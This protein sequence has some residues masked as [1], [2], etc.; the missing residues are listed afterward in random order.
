MK[1]TRLSLLAISTLT[2]ILLVGGMMPASAM[3]AN[4]NGTPVET[5]RAM[6]DI[7]I[8]AATKSI[9]VSR[10]EVVRITNAAGQQF[11]WQFDTLHHPVIELSKIAPGGFAQGPVLV[12]VGQSADELH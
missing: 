1:T 8:N 7:K 12:Y 2:S 5:A 9:N 11:T 3:I 6:R 10:N 4:P